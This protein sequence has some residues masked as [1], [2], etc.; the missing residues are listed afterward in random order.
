MLIIV[1]VQEEHYLNVQLEFERNALAQERRDAYERLAQER[2]E[3]FDWHTLHIPHPLIHERRTENGQ[4]FPNALEESPD[5][6]ERN[7]F[8]L[9]PVPRYVFK[10][11]FL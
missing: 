2:R 3:A 1:V 8:D 9:S 6:P 11:L 10:G 7:R 5:S 4:H